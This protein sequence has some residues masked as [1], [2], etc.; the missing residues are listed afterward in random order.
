MLQL[1]SDN[2]VKILNDLIKFH[3]CDEADISV[4]DFGASLQ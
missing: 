4:N 3:L 2:T 1:Q